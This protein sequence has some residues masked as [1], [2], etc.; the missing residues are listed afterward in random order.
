[1][2]DP[3][4]T[5]GGRLEELLAEE[6]AVVVDFWMEGCPACARYAPTFN[7]LTE[8][9]A[10]KA[11]FVKLEAKNNMETAKKHKIRSLPTTVLFVDGVEQARLVGAKP[12]EQVQGWLEEAL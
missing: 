1:M 8:A 11:E 7:R 10:G 5:D 12:L 6:G 3:L 2:T 9:L 4:E